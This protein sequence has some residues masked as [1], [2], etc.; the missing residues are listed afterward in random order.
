MK[1]FNLVSHHNQQIITVAELKTHLRITFNDDDIY[2]Q[3]L[4]KAAVRMIEEFANLFLRRTSGVQYGN[5][6]SDLN[7]LF[8]SPQHGPDYRADVSYYKNGVW[9]LLPAIEYEY[10]PLIQPARIYGT[11]DFTN[12]QTDDVFQSWK[13]A[14]TLGYSDNDTIPNPLKQCIKIIVADLYENRQSVIV[15]KIVSEIPRTA[16][17]LMNPFKIQTL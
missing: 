12:P 4:E 14:Y 7:I 16:Q 3:E 15:G 1:Y 10:V 13:V 11:S 2:I 8:K 6:F 5:C 17:Y 9:V